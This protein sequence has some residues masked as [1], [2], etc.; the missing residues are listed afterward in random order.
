MRQ[1]VRKMS[2]SGDFHDVVGEDREVS[3][4]ARF[5]RAF[6]AFL[7]GGVGRPASQHLERLLARYR[8]LRDASPGPLNP[9]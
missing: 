5:D 3:Q 6:L 7:E 1:R 9:F 4:F 8:L 2:G